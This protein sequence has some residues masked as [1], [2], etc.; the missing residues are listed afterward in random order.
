MRRALR[1]TD[2]APPSRGPWST[3]SSSSSPL[4]ARTSGAK[5]TTAG[6]QTYIF[7]PDELDQLEDRVRSARKSIDHN[8]P[9]RQV[10]VAAAEYGANVML[11]CFLLTAAK[12]GSSAGLP[13]GKNLT[14]KNSGD[15][16]LVSQTPTRYGDGQEPTSVPIIGRQV[17]EIVLSGGGSISTHCSSVGSCGLRQHEL[18]RSFAHSPRTQWMPSCGEAPTPTGSHRQG[19]ALFRLRERRPGKEIGGRGAREHGIR[20]G[21]SP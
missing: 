11:T 2:T 5:V 21:A 15:Q 4:P 17:L 8:L 13:Y 14:S 16:T 7:V 3:C 12:M 20:G 9:G 18:C 10:K 6:F 1:R 19:V